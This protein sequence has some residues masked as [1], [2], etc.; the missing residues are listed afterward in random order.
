MITLVAWI[1]ARFSGLGTKLAIVGG[2]VLAILLAA[3]RLFSLG[4]KAERDAQG[5]R[6]AAALGAAKE[7]ADEVHSL[8]RADVDARLA[9]WMRDG[10]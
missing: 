4:R 3:L 5:A 2:I 6:N 8:D 10:R 1:G 7:I 9:R